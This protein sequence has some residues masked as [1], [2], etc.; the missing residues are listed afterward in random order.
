M[1]PPLSPSAAPLPPKAV[2]HKKGPSLG[3]LSRSKSL[4][5][6][7]TPPPAPGSAAMTPTSSSEGSTSAGGGGFNK[8]SRVWSDA[9]REREKERGKEA[10]GMLRDYTA[11]PKVI[12]GAVKDD[13]PLYRCVRVPE[14]CPSGADDTAP[15]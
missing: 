14:G 13:W 6:G 9:G 4:M 12:L 5:S 15:S 2:G 7:P 11:V 10:V 8:L 1:S 3:W